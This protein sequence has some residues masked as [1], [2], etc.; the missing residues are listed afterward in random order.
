MAEDT[1]TCQIHKIYK[2]IKCAGSTLDGDPDGLC[3]LH[4]YNKAKNSDM[5]EKATFQKPENTLKVNGLGWLISNLG[6]LIIPGQAALFL[7]ALRNRLGRR[8]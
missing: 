5:F 6:M 4:S 2:L 1:P 8:R 7:L 3:V